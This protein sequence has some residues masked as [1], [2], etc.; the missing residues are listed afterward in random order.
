MKKEYSQK[1]AIEQMTQVFMEL[2]DFILRELKNT[3]SDDTNSVLPDLIGRYKEM[4]KEI[5]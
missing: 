5:F 4:F 1:E 2:G 3:A